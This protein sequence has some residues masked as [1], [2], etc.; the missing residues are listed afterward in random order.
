MDDESFRQILQFFDLSWSGY[1]RVRKGVKKRMARHMQDCGCRDVKSYLA[2]MGEDPE[3]VAKARELLTV[4][5]SRF[6]RDLRLWQVMETYV[7]PKLVVGAG[8]IAPRP[9]RAWSAG[10]SCGEEVY[11]LRIVWDRAEK[12]SPGMPA[13]EVWATD[14]NPEVLEKAEAGIYPQ[15]SLGNL[16]PATVGDCFIPVSEGHAEGAGFAVSETLKQGI[17]WLRH[18]FVSEDPPKAAFDL[19]FLRN[20]LLT[21]YEPPVKI[22]VFTRIM[23][24]LRPGGFLIIGNNE[25]IPVDAAGLKPCPGYKFAFEK[26]C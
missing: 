26:S 20:N 9:I 14:T 3:V 11:S 5:I 23:E 12:R 24:T 15:S 13:L 1:R 19:V 21:Y 17:H 2:F 18:D 8:V 7:V 22:R 6:F 25:R 16:D 10:C 4:S